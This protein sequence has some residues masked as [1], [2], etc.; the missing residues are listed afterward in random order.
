MAPERPPTGVAIALSDEITP[1]QFQPFEA[2]MGKSAFT[3]VDHHRLNPMFATGSTQVDVWDHADL[4]YTLAWGSETVS[5]V[6]FNQSR[7][8]SW[9]NGSNRTVTLSDQRTAKLLSKVVLSVSVMQLGICTFIFSV[10][11]SACPSPARACRTAARSTTL[12]AC[13]VVRYFTEARFV[14]SASDDGNVRLWKADASA[15]LGVMASREQVAANYRK[16]VKERFKHMPE[17]R[18][19][20]T[21]IFPFRHSLQRR[22][23]P[24]PHL[25]LHTYFYFLTTTILE[26]CPHSTAFIEL[27]P[28]SYVLLLHRFPRPS[29]PGTHTTGSA[30]SPRAINVAARQQAE[31]RA[32]VQWL[33]AAGGSTRAQM[34]SSPAFATAAAAAATAAAIG[35]GALLCVLLALRSR[36]STNPA[37]PAPSSVP[38]VSATAGELRRRT[39]RYGNTHPVADVP[40]WP[41]IGHALSLQELHKIVARVGNAFNFNILGIDT[42]FVAGPENLRN[43]FTHS[44]DIFYQAYPLR[45][46]ELIGPKSVFFVDEDHQRIR[47]ILNVGVS[48]SAISACYATLNELAKKELDAMAKDSALRETSLFS[49][50]T[51]SEARNRGVHVLKYSRRFTFNMMA[52]FIAGAIPEHQAQ[53]AACRGD[54]E[55]I[56]AAVSDLAIPRFVPMSPFNAGLRARARIFRTLKKL[57]AE[58]RSRED[59]GELF[60]DMLAN[61]MAG[62]RA[63]GDLL[64]D[65]EVIDNV[66]I[67][68][69][70]AL[71]IYDANL[72][73]GY[74]TTSS[75]LSTAMHFLTRVL[76]EEDRVVLQAEVDALPLQDGVPTEDE[77]QSLPYLDA[78]LKESMRVKN[79]IF[80][81]FR[82]AIKDTELGGS[83]VKAGT[84]ILPMMHAT[85]LDESLYP[86]PERFDVS[87]FLPGGA[88]QSVPTF[89]NIPF[90]AG[91]RMCLGMQLAKLEFKVFVFQLLRFYN[92]EAGSTPSSFHDFPVQLIISSV[93]VTKREF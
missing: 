83:H 80:G 25:I 76:P 68:L 24:F 63:D 74:D 87:R 5:S 23:L 15:K 27:K 92:V 70:A 72:R 11:G 73:T 32:V 10:S 33:D 28:R 46:H 9:S 7:P 8:A 71:T 16:A 58:R 64:S 49:F 45:W 62:R 77:L 82:K 91:P 37:L 57:I 29:P 89:A 2:Y 44:T 34:R 6:R 53:L 18:R 41:V 90:G 93:Y 36:S 66:V 48:K 69:F 52:L 30:T 31:Q 20:D 4:V 40:W 1:T 56:S 65:D 55:V 12:A 35:T 51:W 61:L 79:P 86:D 85:M 26:L 13:S 21:S 88:G 43:V 47:K 67:M 84:I 39:R 60:N 75:L 59:K 50:P 38:A 3:S 14:L 17:V 54:I 81:V 42:L 19:I 22:L 78:F